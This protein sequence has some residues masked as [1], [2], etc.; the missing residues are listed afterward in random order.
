M[1]GVPCVYYGSEWGAQ[2]EKLPGDHE[3][4]AAFARPEWNELTDWIATLAHARRDSRAL[5]HGGYRELRVQPT[6]LVFERDAG[7]GERVIVAVNAGPDAQ[8]AAIDA[9]CTEL[10]DLLTGE[11]RLF[12]GTLDLPPFSCRFWRC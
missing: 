2:G 4:R 3:L 9:R 6:F 8:T 5:T 11:T 1:C 10:R 7:D 12:D